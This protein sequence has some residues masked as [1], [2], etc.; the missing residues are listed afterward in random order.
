MMLRV[1]GCYQYG[2]SNSLRPDEDLCCIAICWSEIAIMPRRL[3]D[4]SEWTMARCVE[5]RRRSEPRPDMQPA[6]LSAKPLEANEQSRRATSK[7][8]RHII[9]Q[10]QDQAFALVTFAC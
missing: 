8:Q 3:T 5:T 7:G 2:C 10:P 6:G 4:C 1:S 9:H